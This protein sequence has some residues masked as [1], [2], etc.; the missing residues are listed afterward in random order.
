MCILIVAA[1]GREAEDRGF[2]IHHAI[3]D[4]LDRSFCLFKADP[5]SLV[6]RLR[7]SPDRSCQFGIAVLGVRFP[8]DLWIRASRFWRFADLQLP[9]FFE[10]YT[11]DPSG[12]DFVLKVFDGFIGRVKADKESGDLP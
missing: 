8:L 4:I 6:G 3:D 10:G 7:Q 5:S 1:K 11:G 9:L 12:A 2:I